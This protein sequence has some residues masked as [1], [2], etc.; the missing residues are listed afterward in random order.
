MTKTT[1]LALAIVGMLAVGAGGYW[2][3]AKIGAAKPSLPVANAGGGPGKGGAPGPGGGPAQA[4]TVEAIRVAV[5]PMP[6]T[7]TA[8]GSVRSD[9]SV[10]LRPEVTGR[11]AEIRF[12]EGQQVTKGAVLVK[13]DDS[14]TR[15]EAEQARANLWLAK[16]KSARAA[17]L[18]QKGFVS[19][20]AKDEAEG[21][22]RVAQATLQSAEARLARTEIRAPFSGVIG[23]R[24]VSVGDYVK[25]GQDMVNLESIDQLKVDFKV[26]ET[27]LRQ[28][29]V[30]QSLQ[31][32]LDAIPGKTYDGRVL[33]INPLVDAAGRSIV[34]RAV[35]R[36]N[37]AAL[38]PGMFARVRLLTDEKADSMA[39]PEQAL[40]PQGEDQF[41]YK[42]V[43]G[44]AQR[45]KVDIGQRREGKVEILRGLDPAD[46]VVTA[47]H[48][49]IRDGTNVRLADAAAA[50][51]AIAQGTPAAPPQVAQA[52]PSGPK[53]NGQARSGVPVKQ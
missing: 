4:V 44:R 13:L 26:P 47:G 52:E 21:G 16:S 39:V 46:M 24:Q 5:L 49:K 45:A 7:I 11:I 2:Y 36:N 33:A 9:E 41:V 12:K 28:V 22:L 43:E 27:F 10:S 34:I 48:L 38:R 1:G 32:A 15:A 29:K 18:H 37:N 3:G 17:E 31:L 51:G 53:N 6:Q 30:G 20:Q 19:A 23:L 8:V 14:V 35:I 50:G 40:V 42:V 25:D